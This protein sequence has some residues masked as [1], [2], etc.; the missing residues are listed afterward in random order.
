[1]L[2]IRRSH[3]ISFDQLMPVF[4]SEPPTKETVQL[5]FRF[6]G[7]FGYSTKRIGSMLAVQA[8]YSMF[9]QLLIF[10]IIARK[11]GSLNTLRLAIWS[12]PILYLVVPYAVLLPAFCRDGAVYTILLLKMT[13]HVLAF[14]SIAILTANSA[15]SKAV[16]GTVNGAAASTASLARAFGPTVTG[17]VHT[18]GLNLGVAGLAWWLCGSICLIGAVESLWMREDAQDDQANSAALSTPTPSSEALLSP[19]AVEAAISTIDQP[20]HISR[21]CNQLHKTG[22]TISCHELLDSYQ[23][24][25]ST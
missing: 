7:G 1:M 3:S 24:A 4:L 25:S 11:L 21:N 16:L 18:W 19:S 10:P 2:L 12:W 20:D 8:V 15:P 17:V 13:V 23:P 14:P 5:P 6:S 9:A 22:S